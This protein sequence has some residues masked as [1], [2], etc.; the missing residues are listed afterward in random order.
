MLPGM[1]DGSSGTWACLPVS[2]L[3]GHLKCFQP[4]QCFG[5]LSLGPWQR[6]FGDASEDRLEAEDEA[7]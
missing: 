6:H 7:E 4:S 2:T 5:K 1:T 3:H